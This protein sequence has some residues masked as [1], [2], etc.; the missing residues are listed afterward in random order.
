MTP[1]AVAHQVRL[2]IELSR[3][4]YWSGLPFPPPGE[5]IPPGDLPEPG[6]K[7]MSPQRL[8]NWKADALPLSHLR[9]HYWK[10][11]VYLEN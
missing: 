4:E 11:N 6:A 5:E 2:S 1:W 7:P 10:R 9:I 3:Q 8:L